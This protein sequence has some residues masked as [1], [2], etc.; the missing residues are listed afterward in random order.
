MKNDY[1]TSLKR[2]I[3]IIGAAATIFFLI[4]CGGNGDD[5]GDDQNP[6]SPPQGLY[7][8]YPIDGVVVWSELIAVMSATV[9]IRDN[10]GSGALVNT[11]DVR[12]AWVNDDR[13][14]YLAVEWTDDTYNHGYNSAGPVDFDGVQV[15]FDNDGDGTNETGEDKRTIIAASVGSQ[16]IDGIYNPGDDENDQ[17]ADGFGKLRYDAGNRKYSAEFLL[18]LI[19]DANG[20][21]TDFSAAP[22]YS[23]AIFE[24]AN[25]GLG[26]V[27]FGGTHGLGPDSTAWITVP[28]TVATAHDYP[29]M[30][31]NLSGLIVF[32]SDHE[33]ANNEIYSF[34]PATGTIA[35][36]TDL[37]GLFKDNPSLSHDRTRVA[38]H[39]APNATDYANYEI[40]IIDVNGTGLTQLT[41]NS[42][43]DGHPG[44][45]PDNLTI[46]YASF[47]DGGQA[48]IVLM[49]VTGTEL[50]DL[51]PPGMAYDDND[52]DFLPD[53]R[54]VF[55]TNRFSTAPQV[56][57]AVMDSDGSNVM[58]LTDLSGVSDHD[59]VG[60]ATH[61]IF[62]RFNKGTDYATDLEAPFTPWDIVEVRLDGT[63]ET[64]LLT[65]GW[66]NWL[67]IY[68][69]NG[70]YIL[71]LKSAGYVA[72]HLMTLDGEELGRLIPGMTRIKYVDW[73]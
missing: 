64:V 72:A 40:Y 31:T 34:D 30:P 62:E 56:R 23:I 3:A 61:T 1:Y 69:P 71:Y 11:S 35:K 5:N 6:T 47:R 19:P 9:D 48:S 16:Y 7:E 20:E 65:D 45:H 2:P 29:D 57:I 28:Y 14:L 68:G 32:T 44:W 38:F 4:A 73:K 39:G 50:A 49:D 42:I 15:R 58:Q 59:P 67:P 17:V 13:Y 52:P 37:P 25:I 53:G 46:A 70:H 54:I 66:V 63:N 10:W 41:S 22:T 27:N 51:T 24:N 36:I 33:T 55:K 26:Q 18:P 21:D 8:K 60:D 12:W 43:L